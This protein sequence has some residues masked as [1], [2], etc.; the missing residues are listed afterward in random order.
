VN[1]KFIIYCADHR[2]EAPE[3]YLEE[4]KLEE[5]VNDGL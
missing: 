1:S 4:E 5:E 2:L 3:E